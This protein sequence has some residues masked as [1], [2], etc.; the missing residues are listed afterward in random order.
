MLN[1]DTLEYTLSILLGLL[2]GMLAAYYI[3][4]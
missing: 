3:I 1:L 4:G 2:V